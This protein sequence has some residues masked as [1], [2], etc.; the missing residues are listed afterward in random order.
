MRGGA[1]QSGNGINGALGGHGGALGSGSGASERTGRIG[2]AGSAT[3]GAGSAARGRSRSAAVCGIKPRRGAS[4]AS[5]E[6]SWGLE[7]LAWCRLGPG[8][9]GSPPPCMDV[10]HRGVAPGEVDAVAVAAGATGPV[11]V[12]GVVPGVGG[13]GGGLWRGRGGR[14]DTILGRGGGGP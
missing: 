10:P 7:G 4:Q 12:G 13:P 3:V 5:Q 8:G 9:G 11:F 2:A 1:R 14:A 6:A